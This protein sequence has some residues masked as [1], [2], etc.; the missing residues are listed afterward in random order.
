MHSTRFVSA[1]IGQPSCIEFMGG[2]RQNKGSFK[3]CI[4]DLCYPF[5]IAEYYSS[6]AALLFS[7]S[8]ELMSARQLDEQS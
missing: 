5:K 8:A 3:K 4:A 1:V 7:I 6:L 2:E